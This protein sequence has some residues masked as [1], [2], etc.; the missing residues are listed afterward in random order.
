MLELQNVTY[1]TSNRALLEGLTC[2]LSAGES[3]AIV[4]PNGAGKSTLLKLLSGA[5]QPT[6]GKVLLDGRPLSSYSPIALA[7]R[8]AVLSQQVNLPFPYT[9]REVVQLGRTATG[10]SVVQNGRICEEVIEAV[11]IGHLAGR[12]YNRLSGGE[13]QRAQLARVLAQLWLTDTDSLHAAAQPI[14]YLLLDEPTASLDLSHQH[15]ILA[16]AKS[17]LDQSMGLL[18]VVHDLNLAT[19]YFD[20]IVFLKNGHCEACG[21]IAETVTRATI[22]RVFE[23]PVLVRAHPVSGKPLVI[24]C[25]ASMNEHLPEQESEYQLIP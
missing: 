18:A 7:R 10:I 11:G 15:R 6:A 12:A 9:V 20:R 13:Q 17:L 16:L 25:A 23:Q 19:A 1:Q 24:P 22:E 4:G 21:L 14:R 3:I 8:R 5:L 2:S